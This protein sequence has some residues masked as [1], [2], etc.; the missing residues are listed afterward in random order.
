[1][2]K[3]KPVFSAEEKTKFGFWALVLL[4]GS[5]GNMVFYWDV[6]IYNQS[7]M[8]LPFIIVVALQFL[9]LTEIYLIARNKK[10]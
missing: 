4:F 6:M 3:R 8:M 2:A 10:R 1:M 9:S 7:A 5:I